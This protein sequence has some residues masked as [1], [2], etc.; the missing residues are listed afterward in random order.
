MN[1]SEMFA[2]RTRLRNVNVEFSALVKDKTGEGRYLRMR[3]LKA[4][5]AE[6]MA[7]LAGDGLSGLGATLR[8]ISEPSLET[9]TRH[10]T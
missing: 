1:P 2:I 4:E 9:A 6:L 7:L 3:E 10:A 8:L 5:R